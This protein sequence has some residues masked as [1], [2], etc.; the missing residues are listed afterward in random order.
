MEKGKDKPT[1]KDYQKELE[2]LQRER[3]RLEFMDSLDDLK[4]IYL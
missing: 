3:A 1:N 4:D 2:R